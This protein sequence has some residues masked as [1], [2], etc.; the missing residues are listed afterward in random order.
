[1]KKLGTKCPLLLH[2]YNGELRVF[3]GIL[4]PLEEEGSLFLDHQGE[5]N[6]KR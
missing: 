6:K 5:Y 2:Y 4:A 1:M 3:F